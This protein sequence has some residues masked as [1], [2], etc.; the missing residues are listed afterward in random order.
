MLMKISA[1]DLRQVRSH[2]DLTQAEM[3]SHIG[4]SP[5]TMVNWE[6]NG[7]PESKVVRVAKVIGKDLDE[8]KR[9]EEFLKD[10]A[11]NRPSDEDYQSWID[12]ADDRPEP[13]QLGMTADQRRSHLLQAFTDIDLTNEL[14]DRALRRGERASLWNAERME[15]YQKF[16]APQWQ[17]PDYSNLSDEDA[18]RNRYGLAAKPADPNIGFDD[19]PHEA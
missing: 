6:T 1:D 8:A 7:V 11:E 14:K 19:L 4:V 17:D 15:R 13:V 2:L 16:V 3:A 12:N 10:A 18:T 5:R 9:I